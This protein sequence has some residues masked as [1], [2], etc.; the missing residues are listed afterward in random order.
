VLHYLSH[1]LYQRLKQY[2]AVPP[3]HMVHVLGR[4]SA[5]YQLSGLL[6]TGSPPDILCKIVSYILFSSTNRACPTYSGGLLWYFV[7]VI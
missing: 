5:L 7:G 1:M 4:R 6:S 3:T 2:F